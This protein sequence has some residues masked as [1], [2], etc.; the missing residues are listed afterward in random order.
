MQLPVTERRAALPRQ[1]EPLVPQEAPPSR[2]TGSR[3]RGRSDE[4][5]VVLVSAGIQEACLRMGMPQRPV[6]EARRLRP[7]KDLPHEQIP[8]N[9]VHVLLMRQRQASVDTPGLPEASEEQE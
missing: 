7:L 4:D 2:N 1:P 3:N 8:E 5:L 9:A 6:R